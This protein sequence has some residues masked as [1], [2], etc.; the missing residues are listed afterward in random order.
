MTF[1]IRVTDHKPMVTN[2]LEEMLES[3]LLDIGYLSGRKKE[4]EL[5]DS[6]P[7][8]L[9]T[10]CFLE[11]PEKFRTIDELTTM[12]DTTKPTIYRHLNKLKALQLVEEKEM[13]L[14]DDGEV[15][16]KGY[17][18]R[19]GNLLKAWHITEL[20]IESNLKRYKETVEK[21]NSLS[22][23]KNIITKHTCP[24]CGEK[25]KKIDESKK[26]D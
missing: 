14:E 4:E 13:T 10:E 11:K 22:S 17:R 20:N 24:N 23:G 7:F 12:L 15:V 5:Y 3:F 26:G 1:E 8:R 6:V 2:D 18:L 25:I 16:K 21:I 9:W 19:Q